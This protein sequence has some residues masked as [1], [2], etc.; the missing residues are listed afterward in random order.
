MTLIGRF[1]LFNH[2]EL[3]WLKGLEGLADIALLMKCVTG[4]VALRFHKPLAFS[5]SLSLIVDQDEAHSY[6]SITMHVYVHIPCCN[7]NRIS[8]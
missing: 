1:G 7:D 3:E 6:F 5:V 4:S 2:Q 8:L